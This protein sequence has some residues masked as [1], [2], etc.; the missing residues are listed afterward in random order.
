MIYAVAPSPLD[1][2]RI[3]AGTDDG[4]IQVTTDGGRHWKDVTPPQLVP[5]AKVSILDAGHFDAATAYAAINTLRLDD[6]RPHILRTHDGGKTWT[7]IVNGIPDGAPVD[8]V[9]E[10]PKRK[11]LLFAGTEREVYV[12]FDDGDHW[13]SLRLNMPATSIR[14][15]IVKDDDLVAATHGRGFWIL[16]DITPLRQIDSGIAQSPAHLFKPE[17]ALRIRWD[18][19]TDT[20]L[21]PDEPAGENPPDGAIIDYYLG[22][23]TSGPVTLEIDDGAGRAIRRYSSADPVP[24]IDPMLAVPKYWARP[25]RGLSAEPGLH[26][27]LWDL[28]YTSLPEPRN[29]LPMQAIVHDTVPAPASPWVLPGR[30][31][32]KLTANGQTYAQPI[33]VKMDPRVKTPAAA[34]AR[35]FTLAKQCYDDVVRTNQAREQ[36]RAVREQ[37]SRDRERAGQGEVADAIAAFEKKIVDVAGAGGGGGRFGGGGGRGAFTRENDTLA[38]VG[39][40]L[41]QLMRAIE[42]A[43]DAPTS[44]AAAA[45]ADRRASL[46]KLTL[47]WNALKTEDLA[48]LNAQLKAASL[49]EVRVEAVSGSGQ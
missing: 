8:A 35:Q 33:V 13:Q 14:D 23:S 1:I 12:S 15:L 30:Y 43:D 42:E 17:T 26:R 46:A 31:T 2:N 20:P 22:G 5:F 37:L 39:G 7:E 41:A 49:P 4:L 44:Q 10:D 16:D 3:W 47:R 28:H 11:G 24:P 45:V 6:M 21:P 27:W 9:R 36:V 40:A 29:Q 48:K 18:M 25:P 34:L 32:V 38:S 19:N